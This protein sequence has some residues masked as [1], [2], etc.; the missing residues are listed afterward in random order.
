MLPAAYAFVYD[1]IVITVFLGIEIIVITVEKMR[2]AYIVN[3]AISHESRQVMRNP[4]DV[5]SMGSQT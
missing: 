4:S 5:N 2:M 1:S 3:A